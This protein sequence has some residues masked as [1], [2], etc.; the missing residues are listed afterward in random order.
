MIGIAISPPV[1]FEL[2]QVVATHG[3]ADLVRAE[4]E[5][6]VTLRARVMAH[7]RGQAGD[8][9]Q[10]DAEDLAQNKRELEHARTHD[11]AEGRFMSVWN[12]GGQVIWI[13]TDWAGDQT[14][15][16]CLLPSEY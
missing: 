3:V 8:P 13:I 16:P 14:V 5:L 10:L 15:T 9:Q 4:P 11:W 7:A 12:L 2:G 1:D 6:R